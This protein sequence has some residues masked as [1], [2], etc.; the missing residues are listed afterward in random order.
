[1][2]VARVAG[3]LAIAAALA[4]VAASCANDAPWSPASSFEERVFDETDEAMPADPEGPPPAGS[5]APYVVYL[6]YADGGPHPNAGTSQSGVSLCGS[7][8]PAFTCPFAP[9]VDDCK[10][11]VQ[12][13]LDRWYAD[14][15]LIFTFTKPTSGPYFTSV[16]TNTKGWCGS[17]AGIGPRASGCSRMLL[18]STSWTWYSP[19]LGT[20]AKTIAQEHGHTVGMVH[21]SSGNRDVME[22]GN[23][24]SVTVGFDDVANPTSGTS[25]CGSIQN[26][27]SVMKARLGAWPGGEKPGPFGASPPA[28]GS[29]GSGGADAGGTG[30]AAGAGGGGAGGAGGAGGRDAAGS[31]SGGSNRGGAAGGPDAADAGTGSGQGKAVSAGC[32]TGG[33]PGGA[34]ASAMVLTI[35][36]LLRHRRRGSGHRD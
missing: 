35:S 16:V 12:G 22:P 21:T 5:A 26:S 19:D 14:F 36:A 2:P 24:S 1:M 31:G 13:Y 4:T 17:A 34:A 3:A 30:G 7:T 29:A 15:N 10:R 6:W 33:A 18:P 32:A 27:H 20:M 9:S 25:D 28:D 11:Q 23:W 8:P